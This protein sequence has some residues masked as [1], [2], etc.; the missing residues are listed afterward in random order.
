MWKCGKLPPPVFGRWRPY[1]ALLPP[2]GYK[3]TSDPL[4]SPQAGPQLPVAPL[5][6][7][8][9][10]GTPKSGGISTASTSLSGRAILFPRDNLDSIQPNPQTEAFLTLTSFTPQIQSMAIFHRRVKLYSRDIPSSYLLD[11]NHRPMTQALHPDPR[12]HPVLHGRGVVEAQ[13]LIPHVPGVPAPPR[14]VG[15]L[16][17]HSQLVPVEIH[18]VGNL[19][20]Y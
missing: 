19:S 11:S 1:K 2:G 18:Q 13:Y 7:P 9:P 17:H 12:A 8:G 4:K 15:K 3:H 14:S 16:T 6:P 20:N 10:Q 5:K